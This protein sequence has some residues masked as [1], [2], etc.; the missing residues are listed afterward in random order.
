M[1]VEVIERLKTKGFPHPFK[2]IAVPNGNH[3][4]PQNDFHPE[5]I[6]FLNEKFLPYCDA[7]HPKAFRL[8]NSLGQL[9]IRYCRCAQ[10]CLNLCSRFTRMI[11][12]TSTFNI[13]IRSVCMFSFP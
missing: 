9:T 10:E 12:E 8:V 3:F 2:H 5:V 13:V 11:Y 7:H 1:S 4:Q 6:K